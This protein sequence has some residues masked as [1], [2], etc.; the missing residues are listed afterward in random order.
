MLDQNVSGNFPTDHRPAFT[1]KR[2]ALAER[3]HDLYE[4]PPEATRALLEVERLPHRVWEPAC[5]PG[6]IVTVLRAAG[7]DVVASDLVD[8]GDPTHFY[9]RDLQRVGCP[10]KIGS[11]TYHARVINE[12]KD[13]CLGTSC[14][15]FFAQKCEL[16]RMR[17]SSRVLFDVRRRSDRRAQGEKTPFC[18]LI[19]RA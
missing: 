17:C 12:Q 10:K 19:T 1:T 6:A 15:W 16:L 14:P 11:F 7:H 4:T 3:G 18:S 9:R 2:A 8:Y 13:D 5:G